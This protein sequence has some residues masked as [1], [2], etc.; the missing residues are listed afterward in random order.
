MIVF[1]CHINCILRICRT[2]IK[3]NTNTFFLSILAPL[4]QPSTD[5][6]GGASSFRNEG[7]LKF[8]TMII[9]VISISVYSR[10]FHLAFN[11]ISFLPCL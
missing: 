11:P 5:E 6:K 3:H 9:S 10:F 2:R 1:L 4:Q 8:V 7:A